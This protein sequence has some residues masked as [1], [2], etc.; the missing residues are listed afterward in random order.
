MGYGFEAELDKLTIRDKTGKT[1]F[2]CNQAEDGMFYLKGRCLMQV[3]I[4]NMEEGEWIDPLPE[5]HQWQR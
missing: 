3:G 5:K 2:L 4:F 1:L